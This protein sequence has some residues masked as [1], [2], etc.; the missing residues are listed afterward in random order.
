MRAELE[1]ALYEQ[2]MSRRDFLKLLVGVGATVA[3]GKYVIDLSKRSGKY[4][5]PKNN[6]NSGGVRDEPWKKYPRVKVNF[7]DGSVR[8]FYYNYL[9]ADDADDAVEFYD[10]F[11]NHF[12]AYEKNNEIVKN[13]RYPVKLSRG[14]LYDGGI[15]NLGYRISGFSEE[16]KN[17]IEEAF[18]ILKEKAP[19]DYE[20]ISYWIEEIVPNPNDEYSID[21]FSNGIVRAGRKR[22]SI[23]K[24]ITV[25]GLAHEAKH[26]E[27]QNV[28]G[29][30]TEESAEGYAQE[31]LKKLEPIS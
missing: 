9:R 27:E 10:E 13:I 20:F 21:T 11:G 14:E 19:E 2:K 15:F 22:I 31:V 24:T 30:T 28:I 18:N 1:R 3:F 8:E 6:N 29:T 12:F 16:E 5:Q 23:R 17:K 4:E 26:I 25:S 7:K